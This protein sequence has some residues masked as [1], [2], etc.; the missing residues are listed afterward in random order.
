[1]QEDGF[2]GLLQGARAG[3]D[4]KAG[5]RAPTALRES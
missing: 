2:V 3:P 5:I 1:M 4:G